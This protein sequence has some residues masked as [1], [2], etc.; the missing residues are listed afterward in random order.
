MVSIL[1]DYINA[2]YLFHNQLKDKMGGF[3]KLEDKPAVSQ[4]KVAGPEKDK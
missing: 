2:Q 4:F 1:N 3:L